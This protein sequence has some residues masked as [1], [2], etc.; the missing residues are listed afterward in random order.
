M[1]T[2]VSNISLTGNFSADKAAFNQLP[3]QLHN[4]SVLKIDCE[5]NQHSTCSYVGHIKKFDFDNFSYCLDNSLRFITIKGIRFPDKGGSYK[6]SVVDKYINGS[7]LKSNY[8][9]GLDA[10]G[11]TL[12]INPKIDTSKAA[13]VFERSSYSSRNF[14]N[15]SF[16]IFHGV[17]NK[18]TVEED[19]DSDTD[20]IIIIEATS[21]SS[22]LD[23]KYSY[24]AFQDLEKDLSTI[25]HAIS[26]MCPKYTKAS[27]VGRD[28][29]IISNNTISNAGNF[30]Y[31]LIF[32][33]FFLCYKETPFEFLDRISSFMSCNIIPQINDEYSSKVKF[34]GISNIQVEDALVLEDV[35]VR[36][37]IIKSNYDYLRYQNPIFSGLFHGYEFVCSQVLSLGDVVTFTKSCFSKYQ[38]HLPLGDL[39][40]KFSISKVTIKFDENDRSADKII[41]CYTCLS[42]NGFF[43]STK[44]NPKIHGVTLLATVM[45]VKKDGTV[46]LSFGKKYGEDDSIASLRV[47]D[48]NNLSEHQSSRYKKFY[49]YAAYM[50]GGYTNDDG[51][52]KK[53]SNDAVNLLFSENRKRYEDVVRCLAVN[54]IKDG[55][56]RL[57]DLKK[58]RETL[59]TTFYVMYSSHMNKWSD[60]AGGSNEADGAEENVTHVSAEGVFEPVKVSDVVKVFFASEDETAAFV[61]PSPAI[62]EDNVAKESK[63]LSLSVLDSPFPIDENDAPDDVPDNVEVL[64]DSPDVIYADL[65]F[66]DKKAERGPGAF[67]IIGDSP[68]TIYSEIA[69]ASK[70]TPAS[71]EAKTSLKDPQEKRDKAL[72]DAYRSMKKVYDDAQKELNVQEGSY[73]KY[74]DNLIVDRS[75]G[76][77]GLKLDSLKIAS[78]NKIDKN[79][80]SDFASMFLDAKYGTLLGTSSGNININSESLVRIAAPEVVLHAGKEDVL[81]ANNSTVLK[82]TEE[83]VAYTAPIKNFDK[84]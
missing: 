38:V 77:F 83:D 75:G 70:K 26:E 10:V 65:V 82:V 46:S 27:S 66:N 6:D 72:L 60:G 15:D 50:I 4:H 57:Y 45:D 61:T 79:E 9:K 34:W 23:V 40:R 73:L 41:A 43:R 3:F 49:K 18:I 51:V 59:R 81:V 30:N 48:Q 13:S 5:L 19:P 31:N 8:D 74:K 62:F 36:K 68:T 44:L 39:G 33:Q 2:R 67:N 63:M 12:G 76:L 84:N 28:I 52:L 14:L 37:F 16:I 17:C 58:Y 56:Y 29:N 47:I 54:T 22:L 24:R 32:K 78:I 1:E 42:E 21:L 55:S 35:S 69:G 7:N 25:N 11:E 64:N 71:F 20:L 80:D 53:G